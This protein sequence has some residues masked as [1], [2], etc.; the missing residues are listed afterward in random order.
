ML[1]DMNSVN[2]NNCRELDVSCC[3]VLQFKMVDVL[4]RLEPAAISG[5]TLTAAFSSQQ[6]LM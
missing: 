2:T 1:A 4:G 6:H 5:N 3:C